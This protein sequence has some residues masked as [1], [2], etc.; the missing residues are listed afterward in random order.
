MNSKSFFSKTLVFFTFIFYFFFFQITNSQNSN[1]DSDNFNPQERRFIDITIIDEIVNSIKIRSKNHLMKLLNETDS[2]Y[3]LYYYSKRSNNS[4][5]GAAQ[6]Q[7]IDRKLDFL[8][9]ILF[10]DCEEVEIEEFPSC[11][12]SNNKKPEFDYF[13]RIR[14]LIPNSIKFNDQKEIIP[15][16]E[17]GFNKEFVSDKTLFEFITENIISFSVRLNTD[18]FNILEKQSFFNK[19]ILFTEKES[20]PLIYKGLSNYFYDRIVFSEVDKNQ[21]NLCEKFNVTKFPTV[22]VLQNNFFRKESP[23]VHKYEGMIFIKDLKEFIE[24]FAYKEKHYMVRLEEIKDIRNPINF[25][26]K[27]DYDDFFE[28]NKNEK[29][30]VYFHEDDHDYNDE[31]SVPEDIKAFIDVSS[32]I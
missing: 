14:L 9:K 32:Y 7:I 11:N 8:A 20:T 31:F 22:L 27:I 23:I 17:I 19:V 3:M 15:H 30:I 12:T 5:I 13:P 25:L 1:H 26:N 21:T 28:K 29:K 10:I 6:L 24:K 2:T 18:N 16:N 4:I